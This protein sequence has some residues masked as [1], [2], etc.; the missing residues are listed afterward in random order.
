MK[1]NE[2]RRKAARAEEKQKERDV[3]DEKRHQ[4][5]CSYHE[6]GSKL[7]TCIQ[8]RKMNK[9]HWKVNE[10]RLSFKSVFN[11]FWVQELIINIMEKQAL[12][13]AMENDATSG[14]EILMICQSDE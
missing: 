2:S 7:E 13:P 14:K 6:S 12:G 9:G 5:Q 3:E 4:Q 8:N 10:L 1:N 11:P